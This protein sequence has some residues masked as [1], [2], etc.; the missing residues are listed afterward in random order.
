MVSKNNAVMS[1]GFLWDKDTCS[2]SLSLSDDCRTVSRSSGSFENV[3][4]DRAL[5]PNRISRFSLDI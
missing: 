3:F 2:S 5:P 1:F 4:S